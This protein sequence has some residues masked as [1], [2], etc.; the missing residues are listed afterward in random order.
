MNSQNE[1]DEDSM[2]RIKAKVKLS[3]DDIGCGCVAIFLSAMLIAAFYLIIPP[4]LNN[5]ERP[6]KIGDLGRGLVGVVT[7]AAIF[8]PIWLIFSEAKDPLRVKFKR[9][10][11]YV[12][13]LVALIYVLEC[14]LNAKGISLSDLSGERPSRFS[15]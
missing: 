15:R 10:F 1:G 12:L 2:N 7:S 9:L 8:L 4:F 5:W 13:W 11:F 6:I 14:C 3:D